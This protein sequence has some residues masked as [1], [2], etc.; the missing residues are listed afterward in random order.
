M[1]F[2]RNMIWCIHDITI[3]PSQ[4]LCICTYYLQ[5]G[6]MS[7]NWKLVVY[8]HINLPLVLSVPIP[9]KI[10]KIYCDD[11]IHNTQVYNMV[12][13]I[14]F[15]D[16]RWV[17]DIHRTYFNPSPVQKA[18]M[19]SILITHTIRKYQHPHE[20]NAYHLTVSKSHSLWFIKSACKH[21]LKTTTFYRI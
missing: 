17:T 5:K 15:K 7:T 1:V 11:I 12:E 13:H 19:P 3:F 21:P 20:I 14:S 8:V 9:I 6:C 18:Y 16:N 4:N 10:H 2:I